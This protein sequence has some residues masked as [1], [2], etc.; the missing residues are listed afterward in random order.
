MEEKREKEDSCIKGCWQ[1]AVSEGGTSIAE[2]FS[3]YSMRIST[4]T[5]FSFEKLMETG[6]LVTQR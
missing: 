1:F 2:A 3:E 4:Q 5:S 6:C